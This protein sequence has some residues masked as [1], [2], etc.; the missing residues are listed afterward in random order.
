[1]ARWQHILEGDRCVT[2]LIVVI[3]L[4]RIRKACVTVYLSKHT[5]PA[6]KNLTTII[7]ADFDTRFKPADL[8]GKITHTG[9]PTLVPAI[10]T[11]LCILTLLL[12]Y[13]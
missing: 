5:E 12:H 6:V 2:G 13:C 11:L 10:D 8:S 9:S 1:M 3:A 4:Y 7:L